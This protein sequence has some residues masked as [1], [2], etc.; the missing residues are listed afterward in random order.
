MITILIV[1]IIITLIC[2][3]ILISEQ[4]HHETNQEW[5]LGRESEEVPAY[6]CSGAGG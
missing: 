6:R 3:A 1:A 2:A 5:V 4:D